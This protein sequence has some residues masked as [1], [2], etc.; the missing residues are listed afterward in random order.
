[1]LRSQEGILTDNGRN[2]EQ[3]RDNGQECLCSAQWHQS[4][5]RS[6]VIDGAVKQSAFDSDETQARLVWHVC[7]SRNPEVAVRR[8]GKRG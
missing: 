6:E 1:M 5:L 3:C 8:R 4:T 7:A 2:N